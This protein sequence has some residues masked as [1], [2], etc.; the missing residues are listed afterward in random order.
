M[1]Y[2]GSIETLAAQ[3]LGPQRPSFDLGVSVPAA[4]G[5]PF[6]EICGEDQQH[7]GKMS[8]ESLDYRVKANEVTD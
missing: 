6:A 4:A 2:E 1:Y 5:R 7:Y 3:H 8:Q